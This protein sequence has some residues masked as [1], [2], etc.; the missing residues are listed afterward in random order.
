VWIVIN[1]ASMSLGRA[2]SALP[3]Y[4]KA[5]PA[6]LRVIELNKRKSEIDPENEDGIKLSEVAGNIEFQNVDF[7]YPVRKD[8]KVLK[9]FNLVCPDGKTTAL[10]GSSG[11]GKSTTASLILRFYDPSAGKVLLDGHDVRSL[12]INWYR[13]L[14]GFVQQEP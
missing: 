5:K 6:A 11:S 4:S 2:T 13:S 1:F 3:D 14:F 7:E 9:E 10:V 12:N 8:V